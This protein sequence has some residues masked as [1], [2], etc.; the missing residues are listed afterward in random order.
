MNAGE[1]S[2]YQIQIKNGVLYQNGIEFDTSK[3]KT[4]F[5]GSGVAIFVQSVDGTFYSSSH[6]GGRQQQSSFSSDAPCRSA[7]EWK[8]ENGRIEWISGKSG[9]YKPTMEQLVNA[10]SD[11]KFQ[12]ALNQT[13]ARVFDSQDGT[14]TDIDAS[15]LTSDSLLSSV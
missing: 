11:L 12:N 6:L 5:S 2:S 4:Q 7:G 8:V 10:V 13:R 1:R 3:M 9:F 15:F 14:E